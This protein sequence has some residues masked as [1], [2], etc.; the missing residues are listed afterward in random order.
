M[1]TDEQGVEFEIRVAGPVPADVLEELENIDVVTEAA[2]HRAPGS[3]AGPG[4]AGRHH[5]PAPGLGHRTARD[6]TTMTTRQIPDTEREYEILVAGPVGPVMVTSLPAFTDRHRPDRHRTRHRRRPRR[7]RPAARPRA[8]THRRPH[9]PPPTDRPAQPTHP[10]RR[11]TPTFP[12]RHRA[13]DNPRSAARDTHRDRP[14]A[15]SAQDKRSRRGTP[16]AY[17]PPSRRD[18]PEASTAGSLVRFG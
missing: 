13:H 2:R 10:R 15:G 3:R 1:T 6:P 7:H 18:R 8:H 11:R 4:R 17:I 12:H 5:Q 16:L 9:R 14:P